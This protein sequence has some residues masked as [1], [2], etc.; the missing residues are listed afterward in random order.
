MKNPCNYSFIIL[1]LL[2]F[3]YSC[4]NNSTNF[5]IND[6]QKIE[7]I[8]FNKKNVKFKTSFTL[9]ND[10][11]FDI[12]ILKSDFDIL[13]NGIDIASHINNNSVI[14]KSKKMLII[15]IDV[16]F[17]PNKVFSNFDVGVLKIKSNIVAEVEITGT[18]TTK[19][20]DK[21]EEIKYSSTQK[22]LFTNDKNLILN[23]KGEIISK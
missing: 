23:S 6:F 18:I 8:K 12:N 4:N 15:P 22:V 13:I 20:K 9:L 17:A 10:N 7:L 19:Q 11:D 21:K 14:V 2:S 5:K 16:D 3:F 1:L